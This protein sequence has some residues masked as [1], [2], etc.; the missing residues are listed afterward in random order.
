MGSNSDYTVSESEEMLLIENVCVDLENPFPLALNHDLYMPKVANLKVSASLKEQIQKIL[1]LESSKNIRKIMFWQIFYKKFLAE[2]TKTL[3]ENNSKQ[4]GKDYV[5]LLW[6]NMKY[7]LDSALEQLP[8]ILS[9]SIH[10]ELYDL[11]KHSR[12]TFDM[13]FILDCYKIIYQELLGI[14]VSDSFILSSAKK[15]FGT[16]FLIYL[17]KSKKK[18]E[19]RINDFAKKTEKQ[20]ENAPGINDF[21]KELSL[22]LR[23]VVQK[24]ENLATE[25]VL[26]LSVFD[27]VIADK[28][29][30]QLSEPLLK[31]SKVCDKSKVFNCVRLG[32]LIS[33]QVNSST[34]LLI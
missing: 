23:P 33:H 11:F 14:T 6:T 29:K 32:P 4:L 9:Y 2:S 27:C 15:L 20:M 7:K 26:K 19:T 12:H 21:A 25:E 1:D 8:L 28:V 10:H 13:R 3:Q 5:K 22:K 16:F 17:K 30:R 34:V 24:V 31:K 18:P